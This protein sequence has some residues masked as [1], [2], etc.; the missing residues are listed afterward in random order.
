[1][2][3]REQDNDMVLLVA[4]TLICTALVGVLEL[5]QSKPATAARRPFWPATFRRCA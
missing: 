4:V 2:G 1:M 3:P 5:A